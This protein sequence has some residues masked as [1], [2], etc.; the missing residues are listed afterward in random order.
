MPRS[1]RLGGTVNH[2]DSR[3]ADEPRKPYSPPELEE[4][5]PVD[6]QTQSI[7]YFAEPGDRT[8][9]GPRAGS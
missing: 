6:E 1:R 9:P 7:A 2:P 3:P 5:G 4:L 8:R